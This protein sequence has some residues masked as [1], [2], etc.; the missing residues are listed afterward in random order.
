MCETHCAKF[1]HYRLH[2]NLTKELLFVFVI[3]ALTYLVLR[4]GWRQSSRTLDLRPKND[5]LLLG[6][7][8]IAAAVYFWG[9]IGGIAIIVMVMVHE[10]GHVAAF[11]VAGHPDATFRLI[12]LMG[13]VASS[14][15]TPKSDL[16][17][18]YISIMGPGICLPLMIVSFALDDYFMDFAP[19]VSYFFFFLGLITGALNFFNLLPLWPLD[20]GKILRVLTATY[21]PKLAYYT[22]VGMCVLLIVLGFYM[23]SILISAFAVLALQGAMKMPTYKVQI[24]LTKWQMLQATAAWLLMLAAFGVGGLPFIMLYF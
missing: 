20:G 2:P 7:L 23:R 4:D 21:S 19:L 11:R 17:Q 15:K 16:H 13:G 22:T 9:W 6:G 8:A 3:C 1:T 14:S 10:F 12:P 18:F 24:S 5:A